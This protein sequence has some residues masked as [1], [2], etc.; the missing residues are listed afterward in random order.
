MSQEALMSDCAQVADGGSG[1]FMEA[2]AKFTVAHVLSHL[3][4]SAFLVAYQYFRRPGEGQ[5]VTK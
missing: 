3:S 5:R 2:E 1:F 4:A